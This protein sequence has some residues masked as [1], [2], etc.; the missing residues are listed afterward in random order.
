MR[1]LA[2][3]SL[4]AVAASLLVSSVAGYA[5]LRRC[6]VLSS[7]TIVMGRQRPTMAMA[8]DVRRSVT[9]TTVTARTLLLVLLLAGCS[10]DP[11]TAREPG[12]AALPATAP[13][14]ATAAGDAP[15]VCA[16]IRRRFDAALAARTD[17]CSTAADCG[18]YNPV[19]GPHLGCGGVTDT[20]TVAKLA[21][22]EQEF[23]ARRCAWTHNCAAWTCAPAC[24]NKRCTS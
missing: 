8:D 23:H 24:V 20:A 2:L 3:V 14:R 12:A 10:N 22:I 15:D 7:K 5:L 11:P 19:G 6:H 13:P 17:S 21:E 9:I 18:C 16:G 1:V 4:S